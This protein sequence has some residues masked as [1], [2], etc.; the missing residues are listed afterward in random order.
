MQ[1]PFM[2]GT[3]NNTS[4]IINKSTMYTSTTQ[5][6]E[7][8]Q[9][10]STARLEFDTKDM[11][12]FVNDRGIKV[13]WERAYFCPC[14]N[15]DTG[16]PRVDCPRCHGKG[17][18]Y[19][20]PKETIMAIQS[21]EKGTNN[22]DIG[23]L[24]TGT[25][26]GTTQLEKRV[27]YRDRFTVPEVLMPQQLIYH[28][29]KERIQKG[30]PLYYD[31]KEVTF[32]TSNDG[33]VYEDDYNIENNRLFMDAKFENKTISLNILM[34]LRY[35]VSDILKESR[36]QYTKFNQ[37]NTKFENLPQKLLLKREDVIVLPEPFKVNDGIEEDLEIQVE[38]PKKESKDNHSGGFFG[39]M[40]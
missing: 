17:I 8:E 37:P 24:D 36:Y 16:H 12:R 39:G 32:I 25:A 6:D 7:Q 38:D 18:A 29:T 15:P 5:A 2:I 30:I 31:V 33:N 26:I 4:N 27:S 9:K 1:K 40:L 19:L 13:L 34:V 21:Q 14:L 10:L 20:P 35:V 3:N 11:R 22:I 28:V 23:I